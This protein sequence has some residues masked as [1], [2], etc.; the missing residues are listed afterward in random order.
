MRPDTLGLTSMFFD[1]GAR[2]YCFNARWYDPE[3]GRWMS[4]DPMGYFDNPNL[5]Q[6]VMN[7]PLSFTDPTGRFCIICIGSFGG[8][9]GTVLVCLGTLNPLACIATALPTGTA[10]Y[11]CAKCIIK[12]LCEAGFVTDPSV[13]DW[14]GAVIP[15]P[16]PPPG[17]DKPILPPTP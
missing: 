16:S 5:Y 14:S 6:F 7:D 1:D 4:K 2:L 11:E 15:C 13:C 12:E 3:R 9:I 8:A 10:L 17:W